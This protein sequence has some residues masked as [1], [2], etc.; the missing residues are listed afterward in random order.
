[1]SEFHSRTRYLLGLPQVGIASEELRALDAPAIHPVP[2]R[3]GYGLWGPTGVGKTWML[4][5]VAARILDAKHVRLRPD[6]STAL[7]PDS[8]PWIMWVDWPEQ[9][10]ILKRKVVGGGSGIN[11]WVDRCK[12]VR[13]L[14]L[15]DLGRERLK[16]NDDY[17]LGVLSEIISSRY[18]SQKAIYWTT[19]KGPE[20]LISL[21]GSRL[22]SRLLS[23]WPPFQ[24]DGQDL[25][26]AGPDAV[27]PPVKSEI[28]RDGRSLAAGG[29]A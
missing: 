15:D 24:V 16:G 8:P 13:F 20:D 12:E 11:A 22:A 23:A 26:L 9:A 25:R 21:Y 19:N 6:P 5:Q 4:V 2:D 3:K 10:E 28:S 27:P 1:M 14:F 7:L 18:R 17:A 29:D